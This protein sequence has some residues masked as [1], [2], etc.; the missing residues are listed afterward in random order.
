M[1]FLVPVRLHNLKDSLQIQVQ[2]TFF[3]TMQQIGKAKNIENLELLV[4]TNIRYDPIENTPD[5]TQINAY[6]DP[7]RNL[8]SKAHAMHTLRELRISDLL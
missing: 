5:I 1:Y 8:I 3:E 2:S 4:K 7:Q 6:Y